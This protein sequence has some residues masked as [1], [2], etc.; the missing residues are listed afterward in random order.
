MSGYARL[1]KQA[2]KIAFYSR[3]AL[4][5]LIPDACYRAV[6]P[7]RLDP[8]NIENHDYIQDRLNYYNKL[9]GAFEPEQDAVRI[10]DFR[11]GK[12][13]TYFIDLRELIRYFPVDKRIHYQF[14]DVRD[15]PARPTFVKSR[16]INSNNH[17]AVLVKLDKLRHFRFIRD[18]V[19]FADKIDKGIWRGKAHKPWRQKFV[20]R[21]LDHPLCDVGDVHEDAVGQ[22][23]HRPFMSIRDQL[24][25]KFI[26]SIE[27]NDVA[28]NL[29]WI[30]SSNSLCFM[31]RPKFETWFMEGRLVPDYHYVELD[32][33][34]TNVDEK[35]DY[36][37]RHPGEAQ[38]IV[39]NAHAFVDQF[40]NRQRE[41]LL[42]LLVVN[43]YLEKS[44][45]L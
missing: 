1:A 45:Q 2:R 30:M 25:Y 9:Q 37:I 41:H 39:H 10:G 12:S 23:S 31:P 33:D 22:P 35:I 5:L 13:G 34:Y 36:Y 7:G 24:R 11:K 38:R 29:K 44:G 4:E 21:Y 32:A 43:K 27:G 8:A 20:Q 28:T 40:R 19:P 42:G 3:G 6:L 26:F 15:I 18:P 16:P 14:G 17:N